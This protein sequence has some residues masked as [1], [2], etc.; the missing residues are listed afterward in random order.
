MIS[1][2]DFVNHDWIV[3]LFLKKNI[4]RTPFSVE[5]ETRYEELPMNFAMTV[6]EI[7]YVT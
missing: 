2:Q 7:E 6:H 3:F 1:G 4:V 5:I